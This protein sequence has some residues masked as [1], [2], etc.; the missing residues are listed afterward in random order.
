MFHADVANVD[1]DIAMLHTFHTDVTNILSGCYIFI[2]RLKCFMQHKTDVVAF[3]CSS[4][5]DGFQ[6]ILILQTLI[7]DVAC[8]KFF[9][10]QTMSWNVTW[11]TPPI[12][13]SGR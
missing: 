9:I 8:V 5:I 10:L 13:T 6:H 2:E 11:T 3:F 1:V 4:L 12:L 7:F